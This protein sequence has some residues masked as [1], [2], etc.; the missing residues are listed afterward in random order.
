M[1]IINDPNA[2]FGGSMGNALG[3]GLSA[4]LQALGQL[5][6]QKLQQRELAK[7]YMDAAYTP[8]Q[9][10]LI[11]AE[12]PGMRAKLM[13]RALMMGQQQPA[14][15]QGEQPDMQQIL[16]LL[17]QG[18]Q[19]Q[20]NPLQAIN[21]QAQEA[22][23]QQPMG[24]NPYAAGGMMQ[25]QNP[26]GGVM[27]QQPAQQINP[28]VAQ[29]LQALLGQSQP[30][31]QGQAQARGQQP[32]FGLPSNPMLAEKQREHAENMAFKKAQ[33]DLR[34][35]ERSEEK[36]IDLYKHNEAKVEGLRKKALGADKRIATYERLIKAA[37]SGQWRSGNTQLI[38]EKLGMGS[39]WRNPTTQMAMSEVDSLAQGFT[40]A[41]NITRPNMMEF[42]AYKDSMIRAANTPQGIA[43]I[44]RAKINGEKAEKLGYEAYREVKSEHG[45]VAPIDFM[46]EVYDK[47]SPKLEQLKADSDNIL[48]TAIQ[49]SAG[50]KIT[51][52]EPLDVKPSAAEAAGQYLGTT[53]DENG[54]ITGGIYSNGTS[55]KKFEMVNGTPRIL[56]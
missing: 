55:W 56:D 19:Q 28:E 15:Q 53:R 17:G 22:R 50:T 9:A 42:K 16:A 7:K 47:I 13:D 3:T 30:Q 10:N 29:K 44:A 54:D 27:P 26:L 1:Q 23:M 38:M 6:L 21:Q 4:G 52:G 2:T 35:S 39:L 18:Q 48:N 12:A 24:P 32:Q 11:A 41:F 46:D 36:K 37:D 5:K 51:Y 43:A 14:Q 34:A 20:G 45:G 8:Q 31:Q 40:D 49:Q 25:S 33:A